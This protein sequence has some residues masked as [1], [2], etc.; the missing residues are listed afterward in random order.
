MRVSVVILNAVGVCLGLFLV[1]SAHAD[2]LNAAT[3]DVPG[4][5]RTYTY[6]TDGGNIV[7]YY[8]DGSDH[9]GFSYD[10][11]TYTTLDVSG[12]SNAYVRG[13]DANNIA[14]YYIDDSGVYRSFV[15][16]IPEP[17]T[18]SLLALGML[19]AWRRR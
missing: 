15:A 4:A 17:A 14:G 12:A 2:L 9:H 5:F 1:S 11:S 10:G 6:G 16:A 19:L 13:I 7:G 3:F 8:S 18:L